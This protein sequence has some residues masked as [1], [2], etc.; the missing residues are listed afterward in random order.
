MGLDSSEPDLNY[1]KVGRAQQAWME[2]ELDSATQND[3]QNQL[4]GL[5]T[6]LQV[7]LR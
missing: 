4:S 1:G 2:E 5:K 3:M 7:L 6:L